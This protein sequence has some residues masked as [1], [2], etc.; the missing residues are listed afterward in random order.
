[1]IRRIFTPYRAI[2][3]TILA[4][5]LYWVIV[6]FLD[7]QTIRNI[8]N[9]IA[10]ALALVISITWLPSVLHSVRYQRPG[11]TLILG[12]FVIWT[13][14]WVNRIYVVIFNYMG[15]PESWND[16]AI[17]GFWPYSYIAAGL[18]FLVAASDDEEAVSWHSSTMIYIGIAIVVAATL[19]GFITTYDIR[20]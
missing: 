7:P 8:M 10:A 3:F 15:Q 1:M 19:Y 14:V 18:L 2:V 9:P 13:I 20:F 5:L 17:S 6:P 12:T 4:P 11:W 16:A